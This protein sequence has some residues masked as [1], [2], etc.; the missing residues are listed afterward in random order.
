MTGRE[1][2]KV[3][4]DIGAA[5]LHHANTVITSCTFL[6]QGGLLSRRF[7]ERNKLSQTPQPMSDDIDKQYRIW[8]SIFVDHV[9]IHER[10]GRKRGP[11]HYGPVLF[12]FDIDVLLNL[13]RGSE[14]RVTKMNPIYWQGKSTSERWFQSPEELALHL[15]YG[16]FDKMIVIQT[17]SGRL[18]FPKEQATI[19]LDDPQRQL[20]TGTDTFAHARSRLKVAAKSGEVTPTIKKRSCQNGC[21]CIEKY[22][23]YSDIDMNVLFGST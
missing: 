12:V 20:D 16:N 14:V 9:D 5:H 11:N 17:N 2:Y 10:G 18:N 13:P 8:D 23:K 4:T 15:S 3:F 21:V 19:F 1:V 22:A 7:V 6:E